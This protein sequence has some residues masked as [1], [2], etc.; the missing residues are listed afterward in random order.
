MGFILR[1]RSDRLFVVRGHSN[2]DPDRQ[3]FFRLK[4]LL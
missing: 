4:I 3:L 2:S 1:D